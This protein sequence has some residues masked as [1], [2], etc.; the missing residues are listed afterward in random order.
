MA[1]RAK[2]WFRKQVGEWYVTIDG[3]QHRLGPDK[4]EAYRRFHELMTKPKTTIVTGS[5]AEVIERFTDWTEVNR[6]KSYDWYKKRID[7]FY[8]IIAKLRVCDLRPF[9]IQEELDKHNWS[10]AYKAGCVTA[11]KRVFNWALEQG[12]I[13]Q[14]PLRGLKK[15]DP[16]RRE[17]IIS[18]EEFDQALG[19]VPNQNFKDIARFVWYTGSRPEEAVKL[20][21]RHYEKKLCRIVFPMLDSEGK[22]RHRIIYLCDEAKEIVERNLG[23]SPTLFLNTK[24]RSWTAYSIACT[25]GRI[26]AKTG[27]RYWYSDDWFGSEKRKNPA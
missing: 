27:E 11:V 7:R 24:G 5:V 22:R 19:H 20:E 9:H 8:G 26:E 13:D 10:D 16:G 4:A 15:P 17:Q 14:S 2:P 18:Q 25:W 21:P 12:Y 23:N 1:R 6:P 3:Q